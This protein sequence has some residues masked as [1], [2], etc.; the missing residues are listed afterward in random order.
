MATNLNFYAATEPH[1]YLS[2]FFKLRKGICVNGEVFPNTEAYFQAQ[3]FR[4]PDASETDISYSK[5]ISIA[6][7]PAKVALLGRQKVNMHFG[8]NWKVNKLTDHRLVNDVVKE[9]KNKAI[10]RKDWDQ[11]S[12]KINVMLTGLIAKFNQYP[13]LRENLKKIPEGT[14]L[15][16]HT[17]RDSY[18]GDGGDGSGKNVL[19]KLLTALSIQLKN[20]DKLEHQVVL[21]IFRKI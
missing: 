2:N 4:G 5:I 11:D 14:L 8:K 7:S 1:G 10:L 15:V 19:G 18:W 9:Y 12:V 20:S 17:N 6:D 13:E 21:E 3:K 16:E